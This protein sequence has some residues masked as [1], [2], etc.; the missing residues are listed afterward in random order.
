M[1]AIN[2]DEMLAR[3]GEHWSPKTVA[4]IN[5]Y[6]VRLV[7]VAGEFTWHRH[8]DTDEF[9]LVLSG[10]LTI[11]LR[12]RDVVLAPGEIFV[13]PRG[14]EHCPRAAAETALLLFEPST[15]VNTGDAGG[16]LTA[17][18]ERLS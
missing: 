8:A 16:E 14:V 9:F 3:F 4:R 7:K 11:Q 1:D 18:A 2:L 17:E 15:V 12:D 10:R 6:D 13:V 5:D